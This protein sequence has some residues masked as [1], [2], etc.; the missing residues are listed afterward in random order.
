MAS[1]LPTRQWEIPWHP[2]KQLKVGSRSQWETV[3]GELS[4]SPQPRS[5]PYS[6]HPQCPD[7]PGDPGL[8]SCLSCRRIGVRLMN[9]GCDHCRSE[10]RLCIFN[11]QLYVSVSLVISLL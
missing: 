8:K 1:G 4:C 9:N 10:M 2:R 11:S 5:G 6:L 3:K 7:F